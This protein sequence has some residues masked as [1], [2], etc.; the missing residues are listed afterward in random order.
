MLNSNEYLHMDK[1]NVFSKHLYLHWLNE[2]KKHYALGGGTFNP[3]RPWRTLSDCA[4]FPFVIPML[5]RNKD[6]IY[7][8]LAN[9]LKNEN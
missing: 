7:A 1:L 3:E 6:N 9:L 4:R 5:E 8:P 2:N